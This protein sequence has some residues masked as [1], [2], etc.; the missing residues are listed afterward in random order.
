MSSLDYMTILKITTKII[1]QS[2]AIHKINTLVALT[3]I[4]LTLQMLD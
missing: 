4:S 2:P 3:S 1:I